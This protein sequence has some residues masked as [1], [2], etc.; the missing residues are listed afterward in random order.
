MIIVCEG[1]DNS[2]K[3]TLAL[4]LAKRLKG[5]YVKTENIPPRDKFLPQYANILTAAQLYGNGI[6]VSDRH[7]AISEPIYGP[8]CRGSSSISVSAA[9]AYLTQ[10][11]AYVYCRPSNERI[12]ATMPE[13]EQMSGVIQNVQRLIDAYDKFFEAPDARVWRYDWTKDSSEALA[14]EILRYAQ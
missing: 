8:I 7:H 14:Q 3:S 6:V 12:I 13:R 1:V 5:I 4:W 10:V 11:N 2:G 9:T